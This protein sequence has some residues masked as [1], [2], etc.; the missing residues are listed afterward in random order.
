M[1]ANTVNS[2]INT[3]EERGKTKDQNDIK[4]NETRKVVSQIQNE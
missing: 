3:L 2:T 1:E 4:K